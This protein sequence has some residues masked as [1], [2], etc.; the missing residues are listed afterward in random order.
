[1]ISDVLSAAVDQ[2]DHYLSDDWID[3]YSRDEEFLN[4]IIRLRNEMEYWRLYLDC[5]PFPD[6]LPPEHVLIERIA[7][8]RRL[9][10]EQRCYLTSE[11]HAVLIA[12]NHRRLSSGI[13]PI[14][15]PLDYKSLLLPELADPA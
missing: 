10:V 4:R 3:V 6:A 15:T 7:E 1:M 9:A 5:A 13:H 14:R 11:E 2:L 8:Q 12:D